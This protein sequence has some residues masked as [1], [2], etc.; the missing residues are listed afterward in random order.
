MR[1]VMAA[2]SIIAEPAMPRPVAIP[3]PGHL[4]AA[5]SLVLE[6]LE[7]IP[8]IE[9][10]VEE[11]IGLILGEAV[12]APDSVP[13]SD[14][15]AM[16]GFAIVSTAQRA[17]RTGGALIGAADV[18][19]I[20][21]GQPLPRGTD[22]VVRTE[23]VVERHTDGL[24]LRARVMRGSDVRRAG[25]ELRAGDD[26]LSAGT[27]IGPAATGLLRSLGVTEVIA[28]RAPT[29]ALVVTGDEVVS[30]GRVPRAGQVRDTNGP[31]L[32]AL[33]TEA[34]AT[35]VG[36]Q[37]TGDDANDLQG[38]ISRGV[39]EADLICV[40][41]GAAGSSRDHATG[42]LRA[43]GE[44][45]VNGLRLRPGGPTR[46]AMV[47]GRPVFALPGNPLAAL[48]GFEALARPALRRLAG[49][50][51]VVRPAVWAIYD[52]ESGADPERTRAQPVRL[53]DTAA[54]PVAHALAGG[55]AML[56]GAAAADGL[57]IIAPSRHAPGG[58]WVRV[59]LWSA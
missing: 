5:R 59:E 39:S 23:D 2:Q 32:A 25:E 56:S 47:A 29:V 21:T 15:S 18:H 27:R 19:P 35:V 38:A 22:A 33:A 58:S 53:S 36:T 31:L 14:N 26:A 34:G 54:C 16:D 41:G 52:G 49:A 40:S 8:P 7:P 10:R 3:A 45:V 13:A 48:V 37:W 1:T 55:A 43:M 24:R 4:D 57:A 12:L 46:L 44:L 20:F 42:A 9:R 51:D 17:T 30:P 28:H 50:R 11:A 6:R